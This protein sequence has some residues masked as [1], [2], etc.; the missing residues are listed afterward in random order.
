RAKNIK[1]HLVKAKITSPI[2]VDINVRGCKP[3]NKPR[4][5]CCAKI[6]TTDKVKSTS[7][8][9][10]FEI[11]DNLNCQSKNVVYLLQCSTCELQYIGQTSTS[12]NIR[13]NN[14]RSHCKTQKH[15]SI[16]KHVN[17]TGH[18]FSDFIFVILKG[19]FRSNIQRECFESYLIQ[20]FGTVTNGLNEDVGILPEMLPSA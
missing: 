17:D 1:D 5:L 10:I 3:C 20:K 12:F 9:Y 2:S 14:H 16:S 7:T 18:N 15:L 13:L 8:N 19:N 4:C 11:K 6:M